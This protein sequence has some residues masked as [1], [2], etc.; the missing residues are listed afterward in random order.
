M[1]KEK[2]TSCSSII[3]FDN[4]ATT[5]V[6][7]PAKKVFMQW[8]SCYNPSSDSK[9]AKP[10]RQ[11][12]EKAQDAI[13]D[14]CGVS[15]ATHTAIFTSGATESNC[16]VIRSCVKAFRKKL[17]ER[18]SDLQPH[19]IISATEHHSIVECVHDLSESGELDVSYVEPAI[20]GNIL[21]DD[22][23][24]E[25]KPNTCLVSIMFGNNE[26]PVINN[27]E[28]IGAVA[29]KHGIPFHSDCV[30]VF[31]KFKIDIRKSNLDALSA[32]AHKFYGLKGIG[33]LILNND[34]IDG[35]GLTAEINGSQQ[36]GLR[37]GTENVPA[38]ASLMAALKFAF[39]NRKAKNKRL[40]DLRERLL[41]KLSAEYPMGDFINYASE[42]KELP[43]FELVSLGPPNDKKSYILP[44]TVLLAICK[45]KGKPFCNVELKK[46]LDAK[47]AVI[48]IG[49]ACLTSNDKASHVLN[50]IGAPP[51]VKR[52]VIRIS[53]GDNNTAG[54]VDKFVNL[55]KQGIEKQ[56][57]DLKLAEL[58]PAK[59]K[60]A[61]PEKKEPKVQ[62]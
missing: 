59:V 3:Y 56:C 14:H 16:L 12:L 62:M 35:Y 15:T 9:I 21:A 34:L 48:S 10:T 20:Y 47:N 38:I 11:I 29:N 43:A 41:A 27:I 36:R 26:I 28:R 4:N 53:F 37:G 55:L 31:G 60:T 57:T 50:A 5:L 1:S 32:S 52:G 61:K 45:N 6:C 54:E 7:P 33:L 30:Q 49:S 17:I 39:T 18:G 44:N 19:I 2:K 23:E 42:E 58:K 25:I 40:F 8:A 24:K 46:F 51:V 22:V 13:L